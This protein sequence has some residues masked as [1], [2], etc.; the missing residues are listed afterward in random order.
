MI[1]V[2]KILIYSMCNLLIDNFTYVTL[3]QLLLD[4]FH[5]SVTCS[6]H[7][8]IHFNRPFTRFN[9]NFT[10]LACVSTIFLCNP[11]ILF[12]T[13]LLHIL[14]IRSYIPTVF[15]HYAVIL[16]QSLTILACFPTPITNFRSLTHSKLFVTN[17]IIHQGQSVRMS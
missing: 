9:H 13:I 2:F 8:F 10:T 5:F 3:S 7:P 14:T 16:S 4:A 17:S 15:S 6:Y 12:N 1:I 11:T